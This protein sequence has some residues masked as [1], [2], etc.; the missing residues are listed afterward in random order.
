MSSKRIYAVV[1]IKEF[2]PDGTYTCLPDLK[3]SEGSECVPLLIWSR[4][5]TTPE[6]GAHL[7]NFLSFFLFFSFFL[8]FFL[9]IY[10]FMRDTQ[11]ERQRHRQREKQT[12]C[13]EPDVGLDPRTPG[14]CPEST[15]RCSTAEP[16][17]CPSFLIFHCKS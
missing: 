16:P 8:S 4:L 5:L 11:R 1:F 13:R 2:G 10:L 6:N 15:G 14:S 7:V 9:F 3:G 12:P 17:T